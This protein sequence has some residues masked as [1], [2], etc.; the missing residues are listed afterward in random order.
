MTRQKVK[1]LRMENELAN[2]LWSM[3]Y[4]VVRG[5]S[6]GGGAR[7]RM[8]PDIV[9]MKG[10]KIFVIEVKSGREGNPLY[11]DSGQIIALQEFARRAGGICYIAVRLRG[12]EWRLH[13]AEGLELTKGGNFKLPRPEGGIK[14]K[15][16][17][18]RWFPKNMKITDY[19]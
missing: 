7:K 11:I 4:A 12:G 13:E 19:I 2:T 1:A 16:F 9:A 8:Q 5:P 6:S 17:D 14:L 15:D 10:G 18:E 3:G